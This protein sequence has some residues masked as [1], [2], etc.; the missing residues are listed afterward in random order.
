[1]TAQPCD[2]GH[3][4][5]PSHQGQG[6]CCVASTG[7]YHIWDT[8]SA[9]CCPLPHPQQTFVTQL[10]FRQR[11]TTGPR[12]QP[13]PVLGRPLETYTNPLTHLHRSPQQT[14]APCP[15]HSSPHVLSRSYPSI[16]QKPCR[17]SF[18]TC[19]SLWPKTLT[20]V[21]QIL[22]AEVDQPIYWCPGPKSPRLAP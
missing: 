7:P 21:E 4:P 1:M 2:C 18:F 10:Q 20:K 16:K 5:H 22:F 9:L 19:L 3:L 12:P 13:Q 15:S 11:K 8:G 17:E 6:S 14:P